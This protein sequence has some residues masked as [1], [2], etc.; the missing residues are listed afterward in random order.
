MAKIETVKKEVKKT[1]TRKRTPK[2]EM[3]CKAWLYNDSGSADCYTSS[4]SDIMDAYYESRSYDY[5]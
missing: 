2:K 4:M 5:Y 1:N 3:S